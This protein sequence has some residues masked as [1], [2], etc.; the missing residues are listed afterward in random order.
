[1]KYYLM[2]S[3]IRMPR[4]RVLDTALDQTGRGFDDRIFTEGRRVEL[5]E[6]KLQYPIF[7]DGTISDISF[8]G[9]EIPIARSQA[10]E[11]VA[12]FEPGAVQRIPVSVPGDSGKYDIINVTSVVDCLDEKESEFE[13]FAPDDPDCAHRAG[14]ISLVLKLVIVPDLVRDRHIFRVSGW[15]LG[16]I[17]SD[18]FKRAL[19]AGSVSGV[20]FVSVMPGDG[21]IRERWR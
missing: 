9:H 15:T 4:R 6:V 13:R 14:E 5:G 10:A 3:D 21:S 17:V 7:S 1:M 20:R 18:L 12:K 19:E 2:V 16:I 11:L 8:E